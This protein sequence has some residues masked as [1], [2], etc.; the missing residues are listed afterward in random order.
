M[1]SSA[2]AVANSLDPAALAQVVLASVVLTG[3][4]WIATSAYVQR[5]DIAL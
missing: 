1:S 3:L 2:V 4:E 5:T